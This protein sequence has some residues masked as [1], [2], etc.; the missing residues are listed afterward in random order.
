MYTWTYS[1][2]RGDPLV[3]LNEDRQ[4]ARVKSLVVMQK[5]MHEDKNIHSAQRVQLPHQSEA[6]IQTRGVL[7][8]LEL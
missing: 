1:R 2:C 4:S 5:M 7:A 6:V 3:S 8:D